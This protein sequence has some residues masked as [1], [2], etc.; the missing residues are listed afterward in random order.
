MPLAYSLAEFVAAI[1]GTADNDVAR[2]TARRVQNWVTAGLVQP[3]ADDRGGR[4]V[5]RRF[6]QHVL[7][8]VAVLVELE[9]YA[10][11]WS[12]LR[13]A[14]SLF[15][16]LRPLSAKLAATRPPAAILAQSA[17]LKRNRA[18]LDRT[19]AGKGPVYLTMQ[20]T[21]GAVTVTIT[22]T[23]PPL[24]KVPSAVVVNLTEVLRPYR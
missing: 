4:G 22:T 8:K 5:H 7:R 13:R 6:D 11:P 1:V 24:D 10:L 16:G 18:W 12:M 9:R 15:N 2:E 20:P 23:L 19:I 21:E 14:T 17:K 3:M